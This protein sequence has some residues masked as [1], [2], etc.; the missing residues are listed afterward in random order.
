[1]T[2][3]L[4]RGKQFLFKDFPIPYCH[5]AIYL[6]PRTASSSKTCS[7]H[8]WS[9]WL[10]SMTSACPE[11]KLTNS[12]W[13]ISCIVSAQFF[14]Y[15]PPS[16]TGTLWDA[17]QEVTYNHC[18]NYDSQYPKYFM[19][20]IRKPAWF[21]VASKLTNYTRIRS[22]IQEWTIGIGFYNWL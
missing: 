19:C 13:P 15:H 16:Y 22:A 2:P 20:R 14:L 5:Q 17:S 1:M 10:S 7:H 8:R 9:G 12:A 21:S 3:E 6:C 11:A 18:F 4:S